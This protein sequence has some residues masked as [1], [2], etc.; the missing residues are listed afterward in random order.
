MNLKPGDNVSFL[1]EKRNGIVKKILNNKM[2]LVEI[3]DGFDIP[4]PIND[5]VKADAYIETIDEESDNKTT[6]QKEE[7]EERFSLR[8]ALLTGGNEIDK[9]KKGIYI[10]F[11]PED[12]DD[13]LSSDFGIYL[14]NHN[15]HDLLFTYSLKE[16]GKFICRDFDNIDEETAILLDIIDKSDLERWQDSKFHFFAFKKDIELEIPPF[17]HEI[18]LRAVRFYKEENYLF[19]HFI[20]EKCMLF[21]LSEKEKPQ[22]P[23]VWAEDKWK[24]E[25][26]TKL[27]G[28][29]IVGHINDLNKPETFPAKHIIEKGIAEVDLHIEELIDSYSGKDN[30]ELLTIQLS[31]FSKMLEC[32]I[33]NKF[34]R[35]IFI[36]GVGNGK[37]KSEIINKLKEM[38]PELRYSDASMRKYGN[39]A[40]EIELTQ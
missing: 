9:I 18:H 25:K 2:V 12:P 19:H 26:L 4:V 30:F 16:N 34:R 36:H 10:A 37:L 39:G 29:K 40:T 5:L 22:Q 35:I 14:L 23:E 21:S 38:Y 15:S 7:P 20:G 8:I 31:Y 27:S 17:S 13:V 33:A 24:H 11:I 32:A 1:N 28:L 6:I 3:E